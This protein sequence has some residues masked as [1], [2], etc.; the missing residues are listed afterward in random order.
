MFL[1]III[2]TRN[3]PDALR[4]TLESVAQLEPRSDNYEVLV[5]DNSSAA[6]TRTVFESVQTKFSSRPWRYFY[7]AMPGLLSG[8]HKGAQEAQGDILAYLDDD[9]RLGKNWFEALC[10]IFQD[11]TVVLTGGPSRP[12]FEIPPPHWL[13]EFYHENE[14][15]RICSWLSLF[16]GGD[17]VKEIDPGYVWGLNY[18]IRKKTLFDLG[19]FHP[20]CAPMPLRRFQGDGETGLSKK[21]RQAG[22]KTMYHP[23]V[24]VQHEVPA[25]RLTEDYFCQRSFFQ[26]VANSFTQIRA[27]GCVS[28]R[29]ESWKDILRPAKRFVVGFL[30]PGGPPSNTLKERTAKSCK[31]GFNFHQREV[32]RDPKL[33][34]WVLKKDY[35]DFKLPNGWQNYMR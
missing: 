1:S 17:H 34:E 2:P 21:I 7:D 33:L 10:E 11:P 13:E 22:L 31:M 24:A 26:G 20:D 15:G 16:D 23:K 27:E 8:R 28:P 18:T 4:R 19:G 29:T 32:R 35:F 6:Q 25:S 14:H 12:I 3:R 30:R 5:V 9:V